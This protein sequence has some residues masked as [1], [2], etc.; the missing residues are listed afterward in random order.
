MEGNV[1]NSSRILVFSYKTLCVD[2]E[3]IIQMNAITG[4]LK[5]LHGP[6]KSTTVQI[7]QKLVE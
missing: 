1:H 2:I 6:K 3:Y 7:N 4:E 5:W